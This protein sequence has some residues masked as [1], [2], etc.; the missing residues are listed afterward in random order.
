MLKEIISFK[1]P[2]FD[3]NKY[4]TEADS[5]EEKIRKLEVAQR[6]LYIQQ[7]ELFDDCTVEELMKLADSCRHIRYSV[8]WCWMKTKKSAKSEYWQKAVWRKVV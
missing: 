4:I 8:M 5:D 3:K 6:A 1:E 2:K 7:T